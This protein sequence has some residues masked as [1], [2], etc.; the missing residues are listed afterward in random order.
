MTSGRIIFLASTVLLPAVAWL[1]TITKAP[2]ILACLVPLS[3]Y[4]GCL[5]VGVVLPRLS[6]FAPVVWHLDASRPEIALTFDD[7]PEPASTAKVLATLAR[8][9][10][11]AT[12][13]VLGEK[14]RAHPETL[15]NIAAAGHTLSIHGDNHD[16]LLS[17]R[18]PSRIIADLDRARDA[19]AAATGQQPCLFRPPV[20]HVSPRTAVAARALGLTLVGCSVRGRDGLAGT[21]PESVLR[22]VTVGL[23]PGAII[24]LHDA[25][26]RGDREPAGVAALPGILDECLR[27]G[28]RCVP[29]GNMV[30]E[31][32]S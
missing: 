29:L 12:F 16:R 11:R 26:E 17:F 10:V 25:A 27:R 31:Q 30:S 9:D 1:L 15:R 21:S 28:L 3:G 6:M 13:F 2:M 23:R 18:H 5:L 19:I 14:A 7:G 20:G 22:R 24:L 8:F 32:S 4:L